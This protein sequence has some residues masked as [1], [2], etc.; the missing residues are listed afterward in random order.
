MDHETTSMLLRQRRCSGGSLEY[1]L[2]YS[3]DYLYHKAGQNDSS[4][5]FQTGILL[6]ILQKAIQDA[7]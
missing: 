3:A 1:L 5:R 6:K 4:E 7:L 2:D